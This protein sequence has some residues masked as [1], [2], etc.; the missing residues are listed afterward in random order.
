VASRRPS[1][2]SIIALPAPTTYHHIL[3]D[4]SAAVLGLRPLLA[5]AAMMLNQARVEPALLRAGRPSFAANDWAAV[6]AACQLLVTRCG[7][8]LAACRC[9]PCTS[10][11]QSQHQDGIVMLTWSVCLGML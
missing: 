8:Y 3:R 4:P 6:L 1:S 9:L 11:Q 10:L 2:R 5:G 7:S